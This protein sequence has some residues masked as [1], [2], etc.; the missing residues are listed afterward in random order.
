MK[1]ILLSILHLVLISNIALFQKI[2]AAQSHNFCGS[3][4]IVLDSLVF[5]KTEK[6]KNIDIS[7]SKESNGHKISF[8][9]LVQ[10]KSILPIDHSLMSVSF[11]KP[12]EEASNIQKLF[13]LKIMESAE[14]K[15]FSLDIPKN[16]SERTSVQLDYEI[17]INEWYFIL[18]SFDFKSKKLFFMILDFKNYNQALQ[19]VEKLDLG[20]NVPLSKHLTIG[21]FLI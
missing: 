17:Q 6:S 15:N 13:S 18:V 2:I 21:I 1:T 9:G 14:G 12:S 10:L 5:N 16:E 3:Y 8:S 7:L 11:K 19:S 4:P 20:F